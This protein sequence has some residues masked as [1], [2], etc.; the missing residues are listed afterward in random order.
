MQ[1]IA[2]VDIAL[3]DAMGKTL[4]LPLYRLLGGYRSTLPVIAIGAYY[5]DGKTERDL[6][7]EL[8]GYK[9]AQLAGVKFKVGGLRPAEDAKRVRFAREVV[10]EDFVLACDANQ[11]WTVD[12]ALDFCK[13]VREFDVRWIEEPVHWYDQLRGLPEVRERGG[14]P[15]VAGQGEISRYGCRDLM[16]GGAVN[17]L[18]FDATIGGGVT[19]WR[20]VA[21]MAGMFNVAMGHHEEPQIAVHLLASVPH[22]LYVEIFRYPARD[23]MWNDLPCFHPKIEN[24]LMHVPQ[25]PGVGL[26]LR[27]ETIERYEAGRTV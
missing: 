16:T 24:G 3:W 26:P 14:I 25:D 4:D 23:P 13:R 27:P 11:A 18:N 10:G 12:Q 19:E 1:A 8:L 21:A 5:E 22:G 6:K 7:D 2:A 9:L 15:V 20:R 17:I